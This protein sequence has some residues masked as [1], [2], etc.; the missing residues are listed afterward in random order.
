MGHMRP[1]TARKFT[2]WMFIVLLAMGLLIV[3]GGISGYLQGK[4]MSRWPTVVGIVK[5]SE[6]QGDGKSVEQ[7][8]RDLK[9]SIK[10]SI[11]YE[12]HI[13]YHYE[14]KGVP[15]KFNRISLRD[16]GDTSPVGSQGLVERYP[17]GMEIVVYYNPED[18]AEAI[19]EVEEG[20]TLLAAMIVGGITMLLSLLPFIGWRQVVKEL[21][22]KEKS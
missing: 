17:A 11:W 18:P 8:R 3:W 6:V 12:A 5:I 21:R 22:P 19:L 4:K 15:Y 16:I 7:A 2:K 10:N 20:A 14:V 1:E 13:I 9:T